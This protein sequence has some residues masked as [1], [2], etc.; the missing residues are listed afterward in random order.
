[1]FDVLAPIYYVPSANGLDLIYGMAQTPNFTADGRIIFN[2]LGDLTIGPYPTA[3][4][5]AQTKTQL[6]L[7]QGYYFVQTGPTSYD[8]VSSTDAKAWISWV[9]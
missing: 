8:M 9:F 4:P 5:A 3:G 6:L 2:Y 1:M 7:P